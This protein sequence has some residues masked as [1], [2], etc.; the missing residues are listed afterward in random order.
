MIKTCEPT[1]AAGETGDF[2]ALATSAGELEVGAF[3]ASLAE[4]DTSS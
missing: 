1:M 2:L 3:G 4:E